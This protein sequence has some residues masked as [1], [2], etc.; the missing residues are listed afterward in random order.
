MQVYAMSDKYYGISEDYKMTF[1]HRD[2]GQ[3][4]ERNDISTSLQDSLVFATVS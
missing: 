3:L 2:Q 4:H 1:D